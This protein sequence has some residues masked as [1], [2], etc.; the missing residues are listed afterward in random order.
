[1]ASNSIKQAIEINYSQAFDDALVIIKAK[2]K[3]FIKSLKQV[4]A[5][6]CLEVYFNCMS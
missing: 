1:M 4:I 3:F 6:T 2:V 5:M